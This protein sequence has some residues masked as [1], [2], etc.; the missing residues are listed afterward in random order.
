M[1]TLSRER[2]VW[3]VECRYAAIVLGW[4]LALCQVQAQSNE[5]LVNETEDLSARN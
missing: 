4:M 3:S 5:T 2:A 1:G